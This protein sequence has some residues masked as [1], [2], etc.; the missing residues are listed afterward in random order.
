MASRFA[1]LLPLAGTRAASELP[2]EAVVSLRMADGGEA[3]FPLRRVRGRQVTVAVPW[4]KT[5]SA[6]GQVHYPEYFWSATMGAH[7][8]YESRLEL[9]RL[10]LDD[11]DCQVLAIAAQPFLLRARVGGR[12]RRHVPDF[13][14][15][16]ADRS[17]RVVNVKPAG[18]LAD[19]RIAE[20]L[21]WPASSASGTPSSPARPASSRPPSAPPSCAPDQTGEEL[22]A[23]GQLLARDVRPALESLAQSR[24]SKDDNHGTLSRAPPGLFTYPATNPPRAVQLQRNAQLTVFKFARSLHPSPGR[25]PRLPGACRAVARS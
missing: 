5:R 4:R 22:T 12:V 15:V 23:Y 11:F 9:A 19:P 21:A 13:L 8:V 20:A 1:G 10:L 7:V 14:L 18:R 25:L 17:V 6:C 2:G 16:H 3:S 24:K